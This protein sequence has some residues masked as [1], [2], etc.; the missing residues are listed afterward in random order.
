MSIEDLSIPS[1]IMKNSVSNVEK[2]QTPSFIP[3]GI[4][5]RGFFTRFYDFFTP[6]LPQRPPWILV[7]SPQ[8]S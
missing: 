3:P 4:N 7:R 5:S 8:N 2:T 6:K 1:T